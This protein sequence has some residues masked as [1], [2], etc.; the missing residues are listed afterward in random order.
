MQFIT[1]LIIISFSSCLDSAITIVRATRVVS[2]IFFFPSTNN[3]L[4]LSRKY[5]NYPF[6]KGQGFWEQQTQLQTTQPEV[7]LF[8]QS[9]NSDFSVMQIPIYMYLHHLPNISIIH[10]ANDGDI[11]LIADIAGRWSCTNFCDIPTLN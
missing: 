11:F 4:F 1:T 7:Q 6:L 5:W 3:A 9:F 2:S 8:R 10:N